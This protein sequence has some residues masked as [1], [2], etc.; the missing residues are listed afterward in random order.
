MATLAWSAFAPASAQDLYWNGG[1]GWAGTGPGSGGNGVWSDGLGSWDPAQTANFN[2]TAGTVTAD[3]VTASRG[4]VF[5]SSG[6]TISGGTISLAAASIGLNSLSTGSTTPFTTTISSVLTGTA[7]LTKLGAGTLVLG[8]ANTF[9]GN[10]AVGAGTLEIADDS[11]L[12]DAANDLSLDGTLKTTASVS[13][14]AGRDI[15]GTG[16]LDIAPGTALTVNGSHTTT[17]TTLSNSGTLSL[18]G[19]TRSVGALVF[20]AAAS[21]NASGTISLSSLS[22]SNV[23]SGSAVLDSAIAFASNGNK[24]VPVGAGGTLVLNGNVAGTTGRISK[25]GAGT[26]IASGSNSTSGFQ[27]GQSGA[28]PTNGGKLILTNAAA[29]GTG[30]LQLNYGT[31]EASAPLTFANGVTIGGR[32]GALAVLGGTNAMVFSGSSNF[33]RGTATSGELRLDVNNAT[34]LNGPIGPATGAGSAS[35]ITIGGTGSLAINGNGRELRETI[36]LRDSITLNLSGTVG[37]NVVVGPVSSIGGNGLIEGNL[38][39]ASGAEL[40]FDMSNTL[41]VAGP[42]VSF[43]GFGVSD[44]RG[45]SPSVPNGS[46]RL[47]SGIA[48]TNTNNLINFG[49]GNAYGLDASRI[50]YFRVG[51]GLELIVVPEP[52]CFLLVVPGLA[53]ALSRRHRVR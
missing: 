9:V 38:H 30:P 21:L 31:L 8:G 46:Y 33:F 17:S 37:G 50:A 15:S 4:L 14:G 27:L 48:T 1:A 25:T 42:S 45:L 11:A 26:L 6:Y 52:G 39:F 43:G 16:T 47:I 2:G 10:L 35:G 12:G 34:S 20:G 49:I 44:L 19:A 3:S 29:S 41:I 5:G 18:Q 28:T 24:T 32:S 51:S 40:I 7:G 23:T 13:L 53:L 36:T 22:A